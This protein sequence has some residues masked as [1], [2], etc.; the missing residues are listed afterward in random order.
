MPNAAARPSDW[1]PAAAAIT[2]AVVAAR[3]VLLAFDRTELFFDEAQYWYWGQEFAFGYYSKPPLIG[4]AI[5]ASTGLSGSD[6]PFWVRL[7]APLFHGAT[8]LVLAHAAARLWGAAA[9][10]WCAAV[11]I[12]LPMVSVGSLLAS[13]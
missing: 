13:T 9:A 7:P 10:V 5:G 12:T 1:L 2:A 4:W 3:V 8:A 6:A 11:Y